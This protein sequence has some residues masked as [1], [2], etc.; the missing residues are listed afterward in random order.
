M[1]ASMISGTTW[2]RAFSPLVSTCARLLADWVIGIRARP[3][4]STRPSSQRLIKKQRKRLGGSSK[5]PPV[6]LRIN[7][8]RVTQKGG[9]PQRRALERP[10]LAL[11]CELFA[12][13]PV[14]NGQ[15]FVAPALQ[16]NGSHT[17]AP[18]QFGKRRGPAGCDTDQFAVI[19]HDVG[20]HRRSRRRLGAPLSEGALICLRDPC[21]PDSP[22]GPP[23]ITVSPSIRTSDPK[24]TLS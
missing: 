20:R 2:R 17:L 5:T 23:S 10:L 4:T 24:G 18:G 9:T 21:A 15:K 11:L 6:R 13:H 16:A 19:Q 7:A 8:G 14:Q 3:P 1:F 12:V 22:P